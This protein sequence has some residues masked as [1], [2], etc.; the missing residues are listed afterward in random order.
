MTHFLQQV[1]WQLCV[2]QIYWAIFSTAFDHSVSLLHFDNSH[3]TLN[4]FAMVIFAMEIYNQILM[5]LL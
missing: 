3:G 5:F 1:L 2:K 4:F